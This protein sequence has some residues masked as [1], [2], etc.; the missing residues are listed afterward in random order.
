MLFFI[1]KF[2]LALGKI[3]PEHKHQSLP[4]IR[5]LPNHR[6]REVLPADL[7][8]RTGLAALDRQH[9]IEQKHAL[10]SPLR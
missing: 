5:Q 9:G 2:L 1:N 4:I 8:V 6:I 3:A 10:L 7:F